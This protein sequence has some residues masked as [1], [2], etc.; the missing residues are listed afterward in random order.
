[1]NYRNDLEIDQND[2]DTCCLRQPVLFDQYAQA[3]MPLYKKRDELK[4]M[5]DQTNARLDG[6]IREAASAD[7]KKITEA[8]I[9]NEIIRNPQYTDLQQKFINICAEIKEAEIIRDAFSQRKDM[10]KLLVELFISGYW[11][12]VSPKVVK[13]QATESIKEKLQKKIA[14]S[15]D[16][17]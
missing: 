16:K 1:M 2:L 4:L 11:S 10:L 9:Q 13:R 7:G 15:N 3:L 6:I 12:S 5:I 8:M 17:K 14:E